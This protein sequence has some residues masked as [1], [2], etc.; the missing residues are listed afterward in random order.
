MSI[1]I[2]KTNKEKLHDYEFVKP[3]EDILKNI[4]VSFFT[5]HYKEIK[6]DDLIKADKIVICGNSLKEKGFLKDV[7]KFEWVKKIN[8][9]IFGIC[10]G[11][12]I[13]GLVFGGKV[14]NKTEIGFF[15][16][17]FSRE[18]LGIRVDQEVWHLHNNFI[19]FKKMKEFDVFAESNGISQAVKHKEK[20]IYGVLF[21][22]E[23]RQKDLIKRFIGLR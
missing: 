10:A 8:K 9:P 7:K 5:R 21:H 11:M 12:Q 13:I 15:R 2:I 4:G 3:I 14:K 18:F 19:D 23:V 20:E 6:E 16:E 22:P 17:K 1:L